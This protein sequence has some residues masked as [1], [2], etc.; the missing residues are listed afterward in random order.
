MVT[1]GIH[2]QV[3]RVAAGRAC[4]QVVEEVAT[5][6]VTPVASIHVRARWF[7]TAKGAMQV[8]NDVYVICKWKGICFQLFTVQLKI[9]LCFV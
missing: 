3:L 8:N 7:A 1:M 5:N 4:V 2:G 6:M 9:R